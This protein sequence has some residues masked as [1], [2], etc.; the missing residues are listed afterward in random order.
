M[1]LLDLLCFKSDSVYLG[2]FEGIVCWEMNCQEK[3]SSLI[4]T[5]NLK[6]RTNL[7]YFRREW[8]NTSFPQLHIIN[9]NVNLYLENSFKAAKNTTTVT[10]FNIK[11]LSNPKGATSVVQHLLTGPMIVACQW[12]TAENR[13]QKLGHKENPQVCELT[14]IGALNSLQFPG[15]TV[16]LVTFFIKDIVL[17][18]LCPLLY[19]RVKVF[20]TRKTS[21]QP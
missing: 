4:R 21:S 18:E 10:N 1:A 5:V 2:W 7:T 20:T 17:P 11:M 15:N 16:Y 14:G 13:K 12:N 19:F 3:N 8:S 6:T 9:S